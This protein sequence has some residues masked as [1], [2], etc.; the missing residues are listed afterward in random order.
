VRPPRLLLIGDSS[1]D[2]FRRAIES[3]AGADR[4]AVAE[5][6]A[7]SQVLATDPRP[8]DLVV[9]LQSWPG[10]F[11]H[12]QVARMAQLAPL[13]RMVR[14]AGSWCEGEGRSGVSGAAAMRI[15][16]HQWPSRAGDAMTRL[17]DG[18]CPIWGLPLTATEDERLLAQVTRL[19]AR[20]HGTVIIASHDPEMADWLAAAAPMRGYQPV[21]VEPIPGRVRANGVAAALWDAS[22]FHEEQAESLQAFVR[23]LGNAPLI[24][25][26]NFPR[27]EDYLR[28]LAAGAA[29]IISKPLLLSDLFWQLDQLANVS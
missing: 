25:L 26:L 15:Y 8:F 9:L 16:W 14:L 10:E 27:A 19:H 13:S 29:A 4:V 2:E 17:G 1:S 7:A 21:C 3:L 11:S 20:R 18:G 22:Q 24:A 6:N 23:S 12:E 5:L 28:A